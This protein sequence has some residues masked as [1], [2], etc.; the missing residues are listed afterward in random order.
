MTTPS[1]TPLNRT[2]LYRPPS[3]V[4]VLRIPLIGPLLKSKRGRLAMQIPLLLVAAL[5]VYDGFTGDPLAS[6]NLATAGAWVHYR[7]LVILAL[8]L[9]GNLFCMGCPF[10][11]PRT[12]ARRLS[13]RGR[14]FPKWLRNKWTAIGLLFIFFWLYEWLDLWA[15]P[16]LTAWVIIAYF[17]ASFVLEAVFTE[18]AF[19]KYICPLGTFNFVYSATSPLQIQVKN[20]ATCQTCVGK[21]CVRGS[22]APQPII[23]VDS[24]TEGVPTRTHEHNPQGVLGCGLELYAPQIKSNLDCTMCLDCVRACPHDNIA[25][26]TRNPLRELLDLRAYPKRWDIAFLFIALS[27]MG[28]L[29]AFGMISPVYGLLQSFSRL[30]GIVN[31][32]AVLFLFFALGMLLIPAGLTLGAAWLSKQFGATTKAGA[33]KQTFTAFAPA[34]IPLGAGIW[35]SHYLFHFLSGAL[36]IVPVTQQFLLQHGIAL[37]GEP[38]WTLGPVLPT[39]TID[40]LEVGLLLGGYLISAIVARRIAGQLY[41]NATRAQLAWLPYAVLFLGMMLF[42]AWV[43]SQPMEMRGTIE[44][45]LRPLVQALSVN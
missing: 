17:V 24:I 8:L 41:R 4:D 37:F 7:G 11:V 42:A 31:E 12:L 38:N 34:F 26:A 19:C 39:G 43:M 16:M 10:T 25:L 5:L 22:Y 6:R 13:L 9:A 27:F 32:G 14:R 36:T 40:V 3:M 20:R 30:T 35:A 28:L 21:E 1:T 15:S 18:S 23:L 29:N 45:S 44:L 2:P 33:F